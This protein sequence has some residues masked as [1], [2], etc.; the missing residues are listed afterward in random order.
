MTSPEFT[1]EQLFQQAQGNQT[2]FVLATIAYLKEQGRTPQ[3]WATFIGNR[4][5]PSWDEVKGQGAKAA[6]EAV[7]LNFVSAGGTVQSF[8]GDETHAEAV[9]ANWPPAEMMQPLGLTLEDI[10]P[11]HEIFTPIAAY[12]NL[13]Y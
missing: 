2:A 6:M 8:G 7:V 11:F 13:R 4:F 1:S 12:L 9:V 3:E 10:D 5:A